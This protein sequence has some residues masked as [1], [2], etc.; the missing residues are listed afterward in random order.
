[1][2]YF[3]LCYKGNSSIIVDWIRGKDGFKK[4]KCKQ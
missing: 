4:I 2:T 3:L 1:M